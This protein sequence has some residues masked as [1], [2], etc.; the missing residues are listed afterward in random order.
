[1]SA[2]E[3]PFEFTTKYFVPPNTIQ[4]M[5]W[6]QAGLVVYF[7]GIMFTAIAYVYVYVNYYTY[8]DR[9]SAITNAYLFGKNPQVQFESYIKNAQ[10]ESISA[11]VNDIQTASSNISTTN[12]RLNDNASRLSRKID[13]EVQ[14]KYADAN[15]LGISIQGNIAKLRDAISKLGGAFVLNNYMTNGAVM[16]TKDV[17]IRE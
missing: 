2:I 1:M 15:N 5:K 12:A 9:I 13:T 7:F 17:K 10:A 8:Q 14:D 4:Y 16:T 11:A 6:G 3:T